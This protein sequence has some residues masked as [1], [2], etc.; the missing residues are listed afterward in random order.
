MEREKKLI[1]ISFIILASL[2]S[3][4]KEETELNIVSAKEPVVGVETLEEAKQIYNDINL[5]DILN[6]IETP[7]GISL[8]KNKIEVAYFV[9]RNVN[10]YE[11]IWEGSGYPVFLSNFTIFENYIKLEFI[12]IWIGAEVLVVGDKREVYKYNVLIDKDFII[13]VI[14]GKSTILEVSPEFQL[15]DVPDSVQHGDRFFVK[16]NTNIYLE[17]NSTS[18]IL[19]EI[20][21]TDNLKL[22]NVV[23]DELES[24]SF[25]IKIKTNNI[26]GWMLLE[27]LSESWTLYEK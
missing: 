23:R 24:D 11:C 6:K 20:N 26:E 5:H 15:F 25:W 8:R 27:N 4:K 13:D 7:I 17:P 3:C 1:F 22:L 16:Q 9:F 21:K 14:I 19:S 18:V 10:D 12:K 2:L